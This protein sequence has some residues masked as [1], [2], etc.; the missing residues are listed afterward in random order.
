MPRGYLWPQKKL[1]LMWIIFPQNR[2]GQ[3]CHVRLHA[4]L[5]VNHQ[6]GPGGVFMVRPWSMALLA[7]AALACGCLPAG[8]LSP[9]DGPATAAL[10]PTSPFST[11]PPV[12]T[13]SFSSRPRTQNTEV[14]VKVDEIGNKLVVANPGLGMRPAFTTIGAPQPEMFHQGTSALFI[15]E[16]LVHMCKT[17]G[18]L[19][20][21]LSVELGRMVAE[22]EALVS[23]EARN[24]EKPLPITLTMGNA[25]QSSGLEQ[26]QQAEIA[27]LDCDRR[28]PS[29]KFVPPDPQ[30]LAR[31]YLVAGGFDSKELD[32]AAPLLQE[33]EKNFI[34]E[35]QIKKT[36]T[37]PSWEPK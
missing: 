10:V 26:L 15:T 30:V 19:A 25:G 24:P 4:C 35:K 2:A 28:R 22:R 21:V 33:A 29:K 13:T 27:K 20:A 6:S 8:F 16:G 34:M 14:A 5:H 1:I 7:T 31:G 17:E 12:T 9:D 18:Q 32:A 37:T 11:P 3:N 23:P 36:P